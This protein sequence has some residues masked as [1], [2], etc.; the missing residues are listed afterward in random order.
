MPLFIQRASAGSGK[1]EQLARRYLQILLNKDLMGYEVDPVT[2][3]AATFTREA[4][5]EILNRIL[6]ILS[7]ACLDR[8]VC[9][10]IVEETPLPVPSPIQCQ[11]LLRRLM[12]RIDELRIGTIDSLFAQQA[13]AFVLDLGIAPHWEIADSLTVHKLAQRTLLHLLKLDPL[14]A[15]DWKILHHFQ[16]SLS[17]VKKGA[18]LLEKNRFVARHELLETTPEKKSPPR[19]VS[20][21]DQTSIHHF[22]SSFHIPLTGQGKPN[23]HWIAA[24][25]K[26]EEAFSQPLYLKDVL[27]H[28]PLFSQ[29]LHEEPRFYGKEIPHEFI[30]FFS[31][32][33]EASQAEQQRLALLREGAL[34]R[35]VHDYH[36]L[37]SDYSFDEGRYTFQEI[38]EI[39]SLSSQKISK[40]EI[41]FQMDLSTEHLLIDEYQDT[42]ERQHAFLSPLIGDVL[43]KG[44][45]AF[46]VGDVKQG[47][48]GWRGGKRHLLGSLEKDYESYLQKTKLH[49]TSYRSSPAILA[50]VNHVFEALKNSDVVEGMNAGEPFKEA[51]ARWS[52]E[53]EPQ[54]SA[55]SVVGLKG[56]VTLHKIPVAL[57]ELQDEIMELVIQKAVELVVAHRREDPLREIA[58]LVR[59]TKFIPSLLLNLRESG[60]LASGEGG[61][62]LADTLAVEVLLSLL[63]WMEHPG[64]SAAY[65]HVH[66]SP[67]GDL[68]KEQGASP[69][70]QGAALRELLVDRGYAT[71]LR[72]WATRP[73]FQEACSDYEKE[74]LEQFIAM[75]SRFE[76]LGGGAPSDLVAR[77]REERVESPLSRG[78]RVLSMHA[79][80]GLEFESVVLMDLDTSIFGG[81]AHAMRVQTT[82]DGKFFIQ[83]NREMTLLQGREHL[84][85]IH[86]EEQWE[87]ALSLL[88]VA[89]TRAICFLDIV[90]MDDVNR[91]IPKKSMAGWLRVSG[92]EDHQLDGLSLREQRT[93]TALAPIFHTDLLRK[94]GSQMD[95][96]L[97]SKSSSDSRDSYSP[98]SKY[99]S[100]LTRSLPLVSPFQGCP[101]KARAVSPAVS[102]LPVV[103]HQPSQPPRHDQYEICGLESNSDKKKPCSFEVTSLQRSPLLLKRTPSKEN[104][105]G[106]HALS[107][108]FYD[109][110]ARSYGIV[111]HRALAQIEWINRT[112]S[113]PL[114]E[115]L[116]KKEDHAVF[117]EEYFFSKWKKWGITTLEV[118]RER[119][120][121]VIQKNELLVGTFDRVIIGSLEKPMV[122][123]IVDFKSA[124]AQD[125]ERRCHHYELQLE[126][127]RKA[128][129]HL[130]PTL[131]HIETKIVWI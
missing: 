1:T 108:Y 47:I 3:V 92:L 80:K 84:L 116:E 86:Q 13:R 82:D 62:P 102:R 18:L 71:C 72:A 43:A 106:L 28:S 95:A 35:L 38:E 19:R 11:R 55:T 6:K 73:V 48:Y 87:E 90:L 63:S 34:H 8:S 42:S 79:A 58:I 101:L 12:E 94:P 75:A 39:V 26:I 91:K 120:F 36:Y 41:E 32:L 45:V 2:I 61:N 118:W 117:D 15:Q 124:P 25:K 104:Q 56:S 30:Q 127:Y 24:I 4:A 22:F 60:I 54:V 123:V 113:H 27:D 51:A 119:R 103:P 100:A 37:R 52:L 128:L 98:A 67:L 49:H 115:I 93:K 111:Q 31:P 126:E 5:G 40:E 44:G 78:V 85:K 53:F 57:G 17:L 9:Q 7:T 66:S 10:R 122:A 109:R 77:A 20:R 121:A 105:K 130:L 131:R 114:N 65:E 68:L 50:A 69:S 76:L 110:K 88:Y 125:K 14:F 81:S 107:D 46:V 29:L 89:M 23:G 96:A 70:T 97:S 99:V 59:R 16:R 64:N 112:A 129:Q 74:R 83:N 21:E 33:I